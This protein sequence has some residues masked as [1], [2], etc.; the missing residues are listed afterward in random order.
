MKLRIDFRRRSLA[1]LG[2]FVAHCKTVEAGGAAGW[3]RAMF[4]TG[5]KSLI[6]AAGN[7]G[8]PGAIIVCD[9]QVLYLSIYIHIYIYMRC[10]APSSRAWSSLRAT[11]ASRAPSLSQTP[12]YSRVFVPPQC[13]RVFVLVEGKGLVTSCLSLYLSSLSRL[14]RCGKLWQAGRHHCL[15]RPGPIPLLLYYSQA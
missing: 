5:I 10:S 1:R 13:S 12:R 7:S 2:A 3:D 11:P 6:I 4:R 14:S 8:K 15:R 9:A